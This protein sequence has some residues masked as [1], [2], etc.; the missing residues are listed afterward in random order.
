VA[1]LLVG[2][3]CVTAPAAV[4]GAIGGPGRSDESTRTVARVLGA[5]LFL[6]A[7]VDLAIGPRTRPVDLVMEVTHAASMLPAAVIWPR[8]RRPALVSAAVAT[9]IGLL[10]LAPPRRDRAE[11]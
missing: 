7:L 8:H 4:L 10:D 11:T 5:R 6:Q 2:S 3:V 9:G 1:R